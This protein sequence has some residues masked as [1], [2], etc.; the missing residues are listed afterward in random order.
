[1]KSVSY[2]RDGMILYRATLSMSG[3]K[4]FGCDVCCTCKR[5]DMVNEECLLNIYS[6]KSKYKNI[7]DYVKKQSGVVFNPAW[8]RCSYWK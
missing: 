2:G 6:S 1:M 4:L 7:L 3:E 8:F 5:F